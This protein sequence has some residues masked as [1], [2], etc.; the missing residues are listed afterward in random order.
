[1]M[2]S[3]VLPQMVAR[4]SQTTVESVTGWSILPLC[5]VPLEES[6]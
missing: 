4:R 2:N 5:E 6:P 3:Q 1:L